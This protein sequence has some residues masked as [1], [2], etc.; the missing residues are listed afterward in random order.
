[1]ENPKFIGKAKLSRQGQ[2]TLPFEAREDLGIELGSEIYWYE[3][4]NCLIATKELVS[5]DDLM[6]LVLKS[7]REQK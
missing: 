1:M 2:L 6:K 4:G 3:T 5:Q 7:K